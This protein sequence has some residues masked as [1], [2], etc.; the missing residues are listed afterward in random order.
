MSTLFD[1]PF[2]LAAGAREIDSV[3]TTVWLL[4][5]DRASKDQV[6]DR[7]E[8]EALS[9]LMQHEA[10]LAE[11]EKRPRSLER[12]LALLK[13]GPG[14]LEPVLNRVPSWNKSTDDFKT[15]LSQGLVLK[16]TEVCEAPELKAMIRT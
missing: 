16:L 14:G 9:F 13:K 10:S 7:A 4:T 5:Y 11:L 15:L 1:K 2:N 3:A 12:V 6:W 8:Q